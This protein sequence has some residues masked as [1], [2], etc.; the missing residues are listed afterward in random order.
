MEA[1]SAR[2]CFRRAP[3]AAPEIF[4]LPLT[5]AVSAGSTKFLSSEGS[6]SPKSEHDTAKNERTA[7]KMPKNFRNVFIIDSPFFMEANT[8]SAIF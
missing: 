6:S 3:G 8:K 2:H 7:A 4:T 1:Q 5:E